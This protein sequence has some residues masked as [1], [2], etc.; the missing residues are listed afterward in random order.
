MINCEYYVPAWEGSKTSGKQPDFC[1]KYKV[2]L[3]GYCIKNCVVRRS[4]DTLAKVLY[5]INRKQTGEPTQH[6]AHKGGGLTIDDKA[7]IKNA[8]TCPGILK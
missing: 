1:L 5:K 8:G 4:V 6:L 7:T 3:N 2:P